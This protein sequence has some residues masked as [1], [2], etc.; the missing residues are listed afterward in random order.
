[1]Q[2]DMFRL[3]LTPEV[4][5]PGSWSVQILECSVPG[6]IGPQGSVT[7]VLSRQELEE[8]RNGAL[9]PNQGRLTDIG[10]HT[11]QSF[12][13]ANVNAAFV[14]CLFTAQNQNPKKGLRVVVSIVGEEPN[15]GAGAPVARMP[16]LPFELLYSNVFVAR[17]PAT[18][19]SRSLKAAPTYKPKKIALPLRVLVVTAT[20]DD[21]PPADMNK[22]RDILK[23]ALKKLSA[24][25]AIEYEF[26]DPPTKK[27]FQARLEKQ[28]FHVV[29]FI[30]H[31]TFSTIGDDPTQIPYVCF[32]ND[33]KLSDPADSDL[34]A[35]HLL[36][37]DVRLVVFSACSTSEATPANQN[38]YK[39][40]ALD[41][42]AQ[43]LIGGPTGIP[44]VVAMQFDFESKAAVAFTEKFYEWL[45]RPEVG[46]DEAVTRARIAVAGAMG[47]AHRAWATPTLF[48]NCFGTPLF[49]IERIVGVPDPATQAQL[50]D[51]Q[52]QGNFFRRNLERINNRP[53]EE[54]AALQSMRTELV[55]ELEQLDTQRG[56]L[57]GD[58]IRLVGGSGKP[59]E[60]IE[61][62]LDLRL[63]SAATIGN[64]DFR[65]KFDSA[66]LPFDSA[67]APAGGA[68]APM[69]QQ[70]PD[71]RLHVLVANASGGQQWTVGEHALGA[72]RFKLAANA[73]GVL[74][75][76][77]ENAT[78]Q[79]EGN[80]IAFAALDSLVFVDIE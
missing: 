46:L 65:I 67:V 20:P 22:E 52:R 59:G 70:E 69:V 80:T 37:T 48:W 2:H 23:S 76:K 25:G 57:L 73:S 35:M 79:Y 28:P 4:N 64:I 26:C 62:R 72:L 55:Q 38:P 10:Q 30:A 24:T 14:N 63:R 21:L 19:V 47:S 1:M 78:V 31:G 9:W 56:R 29:H 49:D 12:V 53:P 39:Y 42:I 34:L 18:P 6:L 27:E 36:N 33:A 66:K 13:N 7:P 75:L 11:W 74:D 3:L 43:R 71:G 15:G 50:A 44:A 68:L 16:E 32:E 8:L 40:R 61:L 41:G 77:V 17:D 51:I 60:T 58:S 45:L 5:Q 54:Q